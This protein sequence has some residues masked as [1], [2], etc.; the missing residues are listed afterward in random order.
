MNKKLIFWVIV[1]GFCVVIA[2]VAFYMTLMRQMTPV[3]TGITADDLNGKT[4]RI[5]SLDGIEIPAEQEY[6]I[7]FVD[8]SISAKICNSLSGGFN[9]TDNIITAYLAQTLM[10][11]EEPAGMMDIEFA[12]S[13]FFQEGATIDLSNGTLTLSKDD[14]DLVLTEA[15]V[16]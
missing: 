5:A 9:V 11:C 2:G 6:L 14:R 1:V 4:F 16:Q 10:F 12:V 15:Q 7:E 8:G 3:D 13:T